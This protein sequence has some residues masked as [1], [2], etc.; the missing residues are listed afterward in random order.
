MSSTTLSYSDSYHIPRLSII[1]IISGTR[2][3]TEASKANEKTLSVF[4]QE[5]FNPWISVIQEDLGDCFEHGWDG[6]GAAPISMGAIEQCAAF[7][8]RLQDINIYL[9]AIEPETDGRVT[10][11]WHVNSSNV[12][13]ISFDDQSQP[14]YACLLGGIGHCGD[15]ENDRDVGAPMLAIFKQ[16]GE[17]A[18]AATDC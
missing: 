14:T 10:L 11:D 3:D 2:G 15:V 16:I 7:L 17:I 1:D 9:P 4:E 18:E 8:T 13:Q 5:D 6:D 12:L